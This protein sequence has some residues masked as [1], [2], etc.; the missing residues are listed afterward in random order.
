MEFY[1]KANDWD[2]LAAKD[3]NYIDIRGFKV[4]Y[5]V[6]ENMPE[7]TDDPAKL[8]TELERVTSKLW[9]FSGQS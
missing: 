8:G 3:P 4:P 6:F 7:K 5:G 2:K 9:N 1:Y